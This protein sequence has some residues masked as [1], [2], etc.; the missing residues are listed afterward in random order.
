MNV[1]LKPCLTALCRLIL[2]QFWHIFV[3][4]HL[5][6]V[7]IS[8]LFSV[9][10]SMF[11]LVLLSIL[12][13]CFSLSFSPF[14]LR[15]FPHL[16]S[17]LFPSFLYPSLRSS[18]VLSHTVIPSLSRLFSILLSVLP[19]SFPTP[20]FRPSPVFSLSFSLSFSPSLSSVYSLEPGGFIIL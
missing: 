12:P 2:F 1:G 15:P 20:L 9:H 18:S 14:S 10:R 6:S 11:L 4:L 5:F 16:Y 13:P 17:V 3:C 7:L 19:P 8:F